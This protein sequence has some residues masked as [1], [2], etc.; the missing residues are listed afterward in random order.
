MPEFKVTINL[1]VSDRLR[2]YIITTYGANIKQMAIN[3]SETAFIVNA[4]SQAAL[5]A[6]LADI[7]THLVE[8]EPYNP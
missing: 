7:R 3:A 4:P 8:I 2:Q 6:A 1:G 5:D